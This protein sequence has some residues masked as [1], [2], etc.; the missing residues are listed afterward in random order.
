MIGRGFRTAGLYQLQPFPRINSVNKSSAL[1]SL[2]IWHC[3]LG[4]PSTARLKLLCN[5]FNF[6]HPNFHFQ[7]NV[8]PQAKQT[9][10]LFHK[11]QISSK[12]AFSLI[13]CDIWGPFSI[14]STQGARY[15]LTIVDDFSRCTWLYLMQSKCQT[16]KFIQFFYNFILTQYSK[17]I[18]TI[19]TGTSTIHLPVLQKIQTDNGSEFFEGL[20]DE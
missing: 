11:N 20:G 8:C 12:S 1:Q 16:F 10:L 18:A 6:I 3:R 2:D 9:R 14:S 5:S 7:C 17:H 13:H 19:S 15:F 4:H